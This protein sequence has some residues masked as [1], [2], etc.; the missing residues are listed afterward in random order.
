MTFAELHTTIG[1]LMRETG[2]GNLDVRVLTTDGEQLSVETV[3][4]DTENGVFYIDTEVWEPT[5][6]E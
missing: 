3:E 6:N 4:L 5:S 1:N 2:K